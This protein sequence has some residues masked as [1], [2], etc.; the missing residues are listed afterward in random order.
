MLLEHIQLLRGS[1][2]FSAENPAN[3]LGGSAHLPLL[4]TGKI[5]LARPQEYPADREA[6]DDGT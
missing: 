5:A 4:A 6:D 2:R 1:E 3:P